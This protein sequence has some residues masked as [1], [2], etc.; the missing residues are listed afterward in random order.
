[1]R[2]VLN[3]ISG[4]LMVAGFVVALGIEDASVKTM[5]LQVALSVVLVGSGYFGLRLG[6]FEFD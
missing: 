5:F 3:V 2:K 4:L 1:M 6:G